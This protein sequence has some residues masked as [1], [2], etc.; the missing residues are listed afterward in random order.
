MFPG[1][2]YVQSGAGSLLTHPPL[3]C[4]ILILKANVL[5]VN[6]KTKQEQQI[7]CLVDTEGWLCNAEREQFTKFLSFLQK[8]YLLF[9]H[10]LYCTSL[11]NCLLFPFLDTCDRWD[12]PRKQH[13]AGWEVLFKKC[14]LSY[15]F[16]E[17]K[18][19]FMEL[20]CLLSSLSSYAVFP[21][22]LCCWTIEA[23]SKS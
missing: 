1:S 21:G 5:D 9:A 16:P 14:F 6:E 20:A 13:Q 11:L 15:L 23:F 4:C 7:C 19:F 10:L 8:G 3:Y 22:A 2:I 17:K 18:A 12:L